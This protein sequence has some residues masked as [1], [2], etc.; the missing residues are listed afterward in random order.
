MPRNLKFKYSPLWLNP[1][2]A[3]LC[4]GF[5]LSFVVIAEAAEFRSIVALKAVAY[6]APSVEANKLYIMKQGYPV[7]V[8]VNLG[9]WV[10]VRDQRS[11]L[12]WVEGRNLDNKRMVLVT[13]NTDIK[14]AESPES[15]L[16]ATIEKNVVLELL[17]PKINRGW[18]KV[19]HRDGIS[20]YI[21]SS[22]IWGLY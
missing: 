4:L 3:M 10:K 16:L 13:D 12:S 14:A 1:S 21:Q 20:G 19:K 5:S 2:L 18:V 9:D 22:A 11:G 7:E 15:T 8:I 17:S 6:D